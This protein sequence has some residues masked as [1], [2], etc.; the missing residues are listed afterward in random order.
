MRDARG[1]THTPSGQDERPMPRI[2]RHPVSEE[3]VRKRVLGL[4]EFLP[5]AVA[6]A[7]RDP[8]HCNALKIH[9]LDYAAQVLVLSPGSPEVCRAL[10]IGAQVMV[11]VFQGAQATSDEIEVRIGDGPPARVSSAVSAGSHHVG[12]WMDG[13]HCAVIC[14]ERRLLEALCR[15]PVELMRRSRTSALED[16]F[17]YAEALQA[18]GRGEPGARDK[19]QAALEATKTEVLPAPTVEATHEL[20][21][22]MMELFLR[23]IEGKPN[24]FNE[25]LARAIELHK[26]YW[27]R[28]KVS[29]DPRGYIALELT[30]LSALGHDAGIPINVESDYLPMGL[31]RG[32]CLP[33]V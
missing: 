29:R 22:P 7:R 1:L 13:F 26:R 27:S 14:R 30:A 11:A 23:L 6:A 33:A 10:R 21:V 8:I 17:L 3:G 5:K 31:V 19:A 4:G 9:A 32:A 28:E 15:V 25:T 12:N 16:S 18:Y 2:V 24:G 20:A